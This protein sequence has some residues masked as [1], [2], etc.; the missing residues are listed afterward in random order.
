M[1]VVETAITPA[2][3][4]ETRA[5]RTP[6]P[7]IR[8]V[9][10]LGAGT[11]GSRIA[12]HMANA[13]LPVVLL[14]IPAATPSLDAMKKGKP[15]AFFDPSLASHITTGNFDDDLALLASCDWV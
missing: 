9:A 6:S 7:V 10:V 5:E 1:S 15:A 13:G 14:D 3:A 11:M 12:A 4:G 8:K 2:T